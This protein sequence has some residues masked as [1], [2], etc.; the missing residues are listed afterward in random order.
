[1]RVAATLA[2]ELGWD[3]RERDRQREAWRA[4]ARAEGV[5]GSA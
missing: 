2:A 1:E 4:E 5:V 3:D